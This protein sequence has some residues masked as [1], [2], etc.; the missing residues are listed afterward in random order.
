ME[1]NSVNLSK[2]SP[3]KLKMNDF[4]MGKTLGTGKKIK[5]IN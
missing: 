2:V 3:K 4:E 1:S 5:Q